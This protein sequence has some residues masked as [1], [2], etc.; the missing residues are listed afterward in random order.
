[1][2]MR[3]SEI[4]VNARR[5]IIY[6]T[7]VSPLLITW[8]MLPLYMFMTGY[9]VFHVGVFFTI[10]HLASIPLTYMIGKLF[11]R[12]AIRHGLVVIDAIEGASS[13]LY[14]LAYGPIAPLML[15]LGILLSKIAGM[16]YPLYQVTEKILYPKDKLE[17]IFA[18]HMR[19]P[20]ISQLIGFLTLGYLFGY[21][22]NTPEYYRFGFIIIGASSIFTILYLLKALPRLDVKKRIKF[23]RFTFRVDREFK[24][25][26][27]IEALTILAWYLAPEIVLLNYIV[28]VLGLTLFE[29]MVVEAAISVGAI[30]AT[31]I[32]ERIES[33]YRFDIIALGY[34]L[35][36]AWALIMFLKPPFMFVVLAYFMCRF[37]ETLS[38][39]FYRSWLFSKI[40]ANKASSLFAIISSYKRTITLISPLM[41][42]FLAQLN[43]T[44]PYLISLIL[45]IMVVIILLVMSKANVI[46]ALKK[47]TY[48]KYLD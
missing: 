12:V 30:L 44:L 17:E 13:I 36:A 1:M 19:L 3:W 45:F 32:S 41:A 23:E 5:Y 27:L 34:T 35:I 39:P 43:P 16:F 6:H 38:F 14:G 31:Y 25:I 37:G 18:W 10:V 47:Q 33:K 7:I 15:F 26:L 40:P 42:G 4:P 24:I 46:I 48:L 21:I 9:N 2:V 8:Y 11:D 22:F 20:E 28:N 29:V